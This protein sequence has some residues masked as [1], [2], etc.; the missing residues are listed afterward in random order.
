MAEFLVA[1]D[2]PPEQP[3]FGIRNPLVTG[4]VEAHVTND[5]GSDS[6]RNHKTVRNVL[7]SPESWKKLSVVFILMSDLPSSA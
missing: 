7:L 3:R 5:R 6:Q 1:G 2:V 4:V